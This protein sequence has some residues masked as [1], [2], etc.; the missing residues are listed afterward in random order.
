MK[1]ITMLQN[2]ANQFD[3]NNQLCVPVSGHMDKIQLVIVL[4]DY[5][6][7]HTPTYH[8]VI[9]FFSLTSQYYKPTIENNNKKNYQYLLI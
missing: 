6:C 5:D 9:Q 7:T 1:Q 3:L 2:I 4:D 8:N